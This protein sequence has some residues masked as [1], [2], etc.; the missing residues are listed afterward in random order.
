MKSHWILLKSRNTSP[1]ICREIQETNFILNNSISENR[2]FCEI[3]WKNTVE[4]EGHGWQCTAHVLCMLYT[5]GYKTRPEYVIIIT[6]FTVTSVLRTP[7]NIT[8]YVHWFSSAYLGFGEGG[9]T[10]YFE[11]NFSMQSQNLTT[12]AS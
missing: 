5:H 2:A 8:L 12:C 6:F 1:K 10:K 4:P 11:I 9:D 3:A 7:L